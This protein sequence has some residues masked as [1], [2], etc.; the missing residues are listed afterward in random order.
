[1]TELKH[2]MVDIETLGNTP[3]TPIVTLAIQEFGFDE[4]AGLYTTT[5]SRYLEIKPDP[6]AVPDYSTIAWWMDQNEPARKAVIRAIEKGQS[7]ESALHEL[8]RFIH[9]LCP[10]RRNVRLWGN[11]ATF[12]NVILD[13]AYRRNNITPP[14]SYSGH[15][16]YRTLVN[17]LP[18]KLEVPRT[19]NHHCAS[20]DV[21]YQIDVMR[22]AISK[23]GIKEL[24]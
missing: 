9:D 13:E 4:H 1:M 17:M 12:D 15:R 22:A 11:G 23:L 19:G 3:R 7:E 6:R 20:D 8:S 16:C 24:Y 5:E 14:W 21:A 18:E 10:N 2:F